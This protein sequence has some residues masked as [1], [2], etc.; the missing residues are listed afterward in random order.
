MYKLNIIG[1]QNKGNFHLEEKFNKRRSASAGPLKKI[2][3]VE[4]KY[5]SCLGM[6]ADTKAEVLME[7]R[8]FDWAD[9]V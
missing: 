1:T 6:V 2:L 8:K 4:I 7:G 3:I 5:F 9:D